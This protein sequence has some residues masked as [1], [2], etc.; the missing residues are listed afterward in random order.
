MFVKDEALHQQIPGGL[1]AF[2]KMK[3]LGGK[4]RVELGIL[5]R[6]S[7]S[8]SHRLFFKIFFITA[9][10]YTTKENP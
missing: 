3:A 7:D 5:H 9:G 8:M 2:A 1:F 6:I 10:C 4:C